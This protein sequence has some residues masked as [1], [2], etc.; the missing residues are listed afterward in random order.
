MPRKPIIRSRE[1]YYHVTARSNNKE[2]FYLSSERMWHIFTFHLRRLQIEFDLKIAAFVLM[3][4]HYHLLVLSPKEDIDRMMFYFM[5]SLSHEIRKE[6]GRINRIFGG[7]YKGCLIQEELYLLN[8]YKYIYRNPIKAGIT[9]T[10]E[11]YP[12][13]SWH[14]SFIETET[15]FFPTK[16]TTAELKWLNREFEKVQ[17]EGIQHSLKKTIFP[18]AKLWQAEQLSVTD[19][20]EFC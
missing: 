15:L 14:K 5:K 13:S 17:S 18:E 10:I 20:N 4:N 2:D 16:K 8:V 3:R 9:R 7:R 11:E 6:T 1:H 12:Y 19:L